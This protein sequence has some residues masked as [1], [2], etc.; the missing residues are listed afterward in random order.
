MHARDAAA[1]P[2]GAWFAVALRSDRP[3]ISRVPSSVHAFTSPPPLSVRR[4][5]RLQGSRSAQFCFTVADRWEWVGGSMR[6]R[7]EEQTRRGRGRGRLQAGVPTWLPLG[8]LLSGMLF[9]SVRCH[10]L[11]RRVHSPPL[12][13]SLSVPLSVARISAGSWR[14]FRDDVEDDGE[15]EISTCLCA[16]HR[17]GRRRV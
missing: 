9:R 2:L 1:A 6:K 12:S 8:P 15:Y 4:A 13:L 3:S 14:G 17:L 5:K 16:L 7:S 10:D 11:P